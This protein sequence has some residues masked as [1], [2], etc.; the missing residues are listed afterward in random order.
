M[1]FFDEPMI[2]SEIA[3]I[4]LRFEDLQSNI[5]RFDSMS[6]DEKK[7]FLT[8]LQELIDK[9]K[10]FYTRLKLTDDPVAISVRNNMDSLAK[11]FGSQ[12]LMDILTSMQAR[13]QRPSDLLDKES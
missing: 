4:Q 11:A 10:V 7:F 12:S 13:L 2:R 5:G 9:Q 6:V 1:P 8:K 3:D